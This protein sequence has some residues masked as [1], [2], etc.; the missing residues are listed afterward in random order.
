[1]EDS[2]LAQKDPGHDCSARLSHVDAIVASGP[3][4]QPPGNDGGDH[5]GAGER[6]HREPEPHRQ[7]VFRAGA[8]FL[9]LPSS[10]AFL[11][12]RA[13]RRSMAC[14]HPDRTF[15]PARTVHAMSGPDQLE[16]GCEGHQPSGAGDC[17]ASGAHPHPVERACG[18]L[19]QHH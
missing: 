2:S 12:V 4:Q 17:R 13:A 10:A 11:P 19:Q 1:M 6:P 7:P 3:E 15:E 5:P 8:S 14:P 9:Q 18:G 16:G